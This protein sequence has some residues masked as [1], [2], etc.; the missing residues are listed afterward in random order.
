MVAQNDLSEEV[1]TELIMTGHTKDKITG[2]HSKSGSLFDARLKYE[3]ASGISF[4][5]EDK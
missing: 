2:F 5:F 1:I 4:D 3:E